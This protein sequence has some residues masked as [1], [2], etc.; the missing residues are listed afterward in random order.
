MSEDGN[1][2]LQIDRNGSKEDAA[3][4]AR[5]ESVRLLWNAKAI[6][7][8]ASSKSEKERKSHHHHRQGLKLIGRSRWKQFSQTFCGVGH[9]SY[10]DLC[11]KWRQPAAGARGRPIN[12][13]AG[14]HKS[15]QKC[16]LKG[17]H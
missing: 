15:A 6:G 17:A 14:L 3:F 2:A 13:N 11:T 1:A 10:M 4:V 12:A 7:P 16:L 5:P 8:R 9:L